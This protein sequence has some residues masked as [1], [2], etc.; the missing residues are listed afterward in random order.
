MLNVVGGGDILC[1]DVC[2]HTNNILPTIGGNVA[3]RV[4]GIYI[5]DGVVATNGERFPIDL[6]GL[7]VVEV[8]YAVGHHNRANTLFCGFDA[9]SLA[10]PRHNHH[11]LANVLAIEHLVPTDYGLAVSCQVVAHKAHK[12]TLESLLGRFGFCIVESFGI[13]ASLTLGAPLPAHLG[14]LVTANVDILIGENRHNLVEDILAELDSLVVA[15][16]KQILRHAPDCPYI[17]GTARTT[18]FGIGCEGC[19]HM[20]RHINLGNDVDVSLASILHHL[21]QLLLCVVH[22]LAVGLAVPHTAVATNYGLFASGADGREKRVFLDF[23]PPTLVVNQV[24]MEGVDVVQSEDID[25]FFDEL[26]ILEVACNVEVHT[27]VAEARIVHN[28]HGGQLHRCVVAYGQRLAEGLDTIEQTVCRATHDAHT[29]TIYAKGVALGVR[30]ALV[31]GEGNGTALFGALQSCG[32]GKANGGLLCHIVHKELHIA[33]IH[34]GCIEHLRTLFEQEGRLPF[35][36]CYALWLWDNIVVTHRGGL[37]R[38]AP[39][40]GECHR[41]SAEQF[42]HYCLL[43]S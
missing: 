30:E 41:C 39:H 28:L 42:L 33:H 29:K 2:L 12:P 18:E 40:N 37:S 4:V 24:P 16:A 34:I 13:D 26:H 6:F 3:H 19:Y 20:T 27:S 14:A 15:C 17:I 8:E 7:V 22:T 38:A 31:N 43:H 9:T 5:L 25:V 1:P 36:E 23:H 11:I 32:S 35:E 21:A 10:T